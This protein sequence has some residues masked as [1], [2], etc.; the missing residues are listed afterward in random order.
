MFQKLI[1]KYVDFSIEEELEIRNQRIQYGNPY[2]RISCLY[3]RLGAKKD[4]ILNTRLEP[5]NA[6][7]KFAVVVEKKEQMFGAFH[8]IF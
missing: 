5:E 1:F 6:N 3:E 7:D 4:E 2:Q 8:S